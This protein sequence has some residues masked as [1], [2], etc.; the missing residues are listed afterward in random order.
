M[1]TGQVAAFFQMSI[2]ANEVAVVIFFS[3]AFTIASPSYSTISNSTVSVVIVELLA[4][5]K[6]KS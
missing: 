2:Y 3:G 5:K 1:D 6:I 4:K